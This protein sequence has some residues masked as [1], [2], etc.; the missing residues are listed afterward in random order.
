MKPQI[1]CHFDEE[2]SLPKTFFGLSMCMIKCSTIT[3]R[4]PELSNAWP[5]REL[6]ALMGVSE[7]GI[8]LVA[9]MPFLVGG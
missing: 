4:A 1:M 7:N 9:K 3:Q 6:Y 8:Y 5:G 2:R